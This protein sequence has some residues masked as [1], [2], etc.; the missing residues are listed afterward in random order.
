MA[1]KLGVSVDC[2]IKTIF[3]KALTTDT[4][5]LILNKIKTAIGKSAKLE[6]D[7]KP[8]KGFSLN[9]TLVLTKDDKLKELQLK[10]TLSFE[11]MAV[12]MA[13]GT[14]NLKPTSP[15][16]ADAGANPKS[17]AAQAKALVE[18]VL[19]NMVPKAVKAMEAKAGS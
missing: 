14:I 15:A 5:N 8:T 6:V 13:A 3:D 19:E 1:D 17:T 12:G 11:I 9:A 4:K 10:A 7:D 18:G 16:S 2:V